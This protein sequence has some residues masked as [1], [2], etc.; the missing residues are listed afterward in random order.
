MR[1]KVEINRIR[2][3]IVSILSKGSFVSGEDLA[4]TLNL[5]R[6]AISNHI[7][8]LVALGLDIYTVKG[9]GYKLSQAIVMLDANKISSLINKPSAETLIHIEN[10]ISSTND[11]LKKD[12]VNLQNGACILAEAQT[13]GRGRRGRTWVSPFGASIYM[14]MLWRFESGYQSMAG[15]S[16]VIGIAVI[17]TIAGLGYA[18]CQLKWPND[19]YANQKKLCGI[20]IEV[21]G[22]VGGS[23]DAIIG[24]GVNVQLPSDI[25][26][27]E[28][29]YTDLSTVAGRSIDR[30][31]LAARLIE[32]VWQIL[33]VFEQEGLRPFLP[34][35]EQADLF[36][37]Q[38]VELMSGNQRIKGVCKG[39]D[40]SGALLLENEGSIKSYHG[41]EISVRRSQLV[42]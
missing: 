40:S 35:W 28:Q 2:T 34:E 9:R 5:S 10:I 16:L 30:N 21:E 38:A 27:I 26:G 1:N 14:S 22:Q 13:A 8:A 11:V 17:R 32:N 41:G 4:Q 39:V 6:S 33:P 31:E 25:E 7:K 12:A 23:T 29:A 19:V 36:Y 24:I 37:N 15:L 42:S 18:S 3:K 20:L